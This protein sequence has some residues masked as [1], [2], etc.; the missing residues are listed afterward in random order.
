MFPEAGGSSSFARRAFN[1]FVSFFAA[2]AQMLNYTMTI[3]ISA[4]FVPH[5]IGGL[6][7]E[8][9]RSRRRATSSSA[10]SSSRSSA[11]INVVGAKESAGAEHRAGRRRLPHAAAAGPASG[12]FL[13]FSP[14][15]LVHNVASRHRADMDGVLPGDPRRHDRLHR[16]RDDLE[17]G[18]GGQ[19]RGRRRSPRRSS[20]CVIAVFAIYALLPAVALS[21]LPVTHDASHGELPHAAGP[22]RGP[23]RLRGR[24]G[25]RRRQARSTSGPAGRRPSSTSACSPRRSCSSR[26]TRGSSASRG[27]STRWACTGRCP[28]GCASCTRSSA[29]PWIGIMHLRRI[30][31]VAHDPRQGRRS[32]ATCTRSARCCRSRSRT[33]RSSGC[34]SSSPTTT[35]PYRGPGQRCGSRGHDAAAVRGPRRARHRSRRSS[36]SPRCTSTSRSPASA[37]WR[38]A[39]SSTSSTAAARAST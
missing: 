11:P 10:R 17:H 27:S 30:A 25:P 13:V 21:A 22:A 38:S 16:H 37:G 2:W 9:L 18:R 31:C 12:L 26:R 14:P 19:G 33:S 5:Y 15:T 3:A 35:R 7:W 24:P 8:P 29:R 1:E 32:W 6:F 20:A 39:S 23:G 28:T 4:Y 36:S 34:A